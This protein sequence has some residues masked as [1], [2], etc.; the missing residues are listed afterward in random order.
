MLC[1][2]VRI[3]EEPAW[4]A[5]I[6]KAIM[7][8]AHLAAFV[9]AEEP[10]S[11]RLAGMCDLGNDRDA[12]V[13]WFHE[14]PIKTGDRLSFGLV[15]SDL[16]TPPTEVQPTDSPAYLEEQREYLEAEASW[17]PPSE[18]SPRTWPN[19]Q[20]H[21]SING[22]SL[23]RSGYALSQDHYLCSF[24][25]NQWRPD[26][27][28]VYARSFSGAYHRPDHHHTDWLRANL[29]LGEVASIEVDA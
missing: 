19:L 16:P 24:D 20:V 22:Q 7:L 26:R 18:P 14:L 5:G 27:L 17:Q 23:L 15:E 13:Y 1:L 8:S 9:G 10:A 28:R 21:L 25:W 4:I 11:L 6:D 29:K 2:E 3:N 12:H